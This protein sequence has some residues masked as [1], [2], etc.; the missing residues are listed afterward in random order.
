MRRPDATDTTRQDT[1]RAAR[2]RPRSSLRS[3]RRPRRRAAP[4]P[5]A[6]VLDRAP[7]RREGRHQ[8]TGQNCRPSA[9]PGRRLSTSTQRSWRSRERVPA[10]VTGAL[11]GRT[12]ESR[13]SS[14]ERR[15]TRAP[16]TPRWIERVRCTAGRQRARP[17][18]PTGRHMAVCLSSAHRQLDLPG[19]RC[20]MRSTNPMLSSRV[21]ASRM[22]PRCWPASDLHRRL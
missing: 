9:A 21:S 13:A 11:S 8:G 4:A 18:D 15:Q 16:T 12:L 19:S 17:S 20:S 3:S 7:R 14:A 5:V 1:P 22:S 6:G 2:R 10:S